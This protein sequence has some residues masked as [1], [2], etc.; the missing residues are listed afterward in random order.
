MVAIPCLK[1]TPFFDWIFVH[2]Y[3][4]VAVFDL[5]TLTMVSTGAILPVAVEVVAFGR[6][7]GFVVT[8]VTALPEY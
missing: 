7:F 2:S 5:E 6:A 3:V 4:A 1:L 8:V